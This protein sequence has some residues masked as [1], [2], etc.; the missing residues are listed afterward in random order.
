MRTPAAGEELLQVAEATGHR[1][2][3]HVDDF[4]VW[5]HQMDEPNM[6]KIVWHFIDEERLVPAIGP[7]IFHVALPKRAEF[8]NA[9][10]GEHFRIARGYKVPA[11]VRLALAQFAECRAVPA[12]RRPLNVKRGSA[13]SE[14]TQSVAIQ[15]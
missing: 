6:P 14:S 9:K 7:R 11:E 15:Q 13:R 8:V 2:T 12:C 4:G 5:Q 3:S 10:I 1:L